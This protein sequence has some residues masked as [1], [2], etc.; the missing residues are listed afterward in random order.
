MSGRD[1]TSRILDEAE[2][3]FAERGFDRVTV[4]DIT[5][6][7]GVNL[8][9]INYHFGGKEDLIAAVF[10]RRV[11]PL[12]KLRLAAL[13]EVERVAGK[14][15]PE[16]EDILGAFI[17]PEFKHEEGISNSGSACSKLFG[18]CLTESTPEL[19]EVL[20]KQFEPLRA[21][22]ESALLKALPHLSRVDVFWRMKFMFGSLH[23][24]LL[25]RE[26]FVPSWAKTIDGEAQAAQL[27]SFVAAGFKAR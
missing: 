2:K 5:E 12:N 10:D 11:G 17:W 6:T 16:V 19:E 25:T 21:R 13:D 7:A 27:I 18:R 14:K 20:Q 3:L 9:A 15:G 26:K 4:R 24:W 8:A 22:M 1:T 23:H